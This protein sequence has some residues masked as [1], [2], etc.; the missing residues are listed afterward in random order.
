MKK[1]VTLFVAGMV[2]FVAARAF[3]QEWVGKITETEGQAA[4]VR[5]GQQAAAKLGS[6]IMVG[7]EIVTA[8]GSRAKIWFKDE[9]VITL[10]EKSRFKVE[11][12]EYKAG[13]SRQSVFRLITGKAKALVSGWFS[14]NPEQDYQIKALSTVAGV[15]GTGFIAEV[16]GEGANASALFAGLSGTL[17]LWNADRPEIKISLPANFFLEILNGQIPGQPQSLGTDF[18]EQFNQGLFFITGSDGDR[19]IKF[20]K[21]S[22]PDVPAPSGGGEPGPG[23]GDLGGGK[24]NY[25]NP[26][27]LIFQEPPGF[28]P[29]TIII[30]GGPYY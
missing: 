13:I 7:D 24:S 25:L 28:T 17:T 20:F 1:L 29:V 3:G 15:R 22:G 5:V 19:Q 4:I 27:D 23:E 16:K 14:K 26:A 6:E 11:A 9:S 21:I 12:L 10:S 18:L 8:A 2:L 30:N